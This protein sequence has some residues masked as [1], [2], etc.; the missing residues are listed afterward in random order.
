[1][2]GHRRASVSGI[3][4]TQLAHVRRLPVHVRSADGE[5]RVLARAV[6]DASG[7]W[8]TPNPLGGEGLPAIGE[9]AAADRISY[10]VPDRAAERADMRASTWSWPA[11]GT[12]R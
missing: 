12:P 11:A 3:R 1:M 4:C 5:E 6:V 8:T 10:Q 2:F 7:T 9:R